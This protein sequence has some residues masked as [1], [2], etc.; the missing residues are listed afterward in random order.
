MNMTDLA[1]PPWVPFGIK[2]TSQVDTSKKVLAQSETTEDNSS[3]FSQARK[4]ALAE[5]IEAKS[6]VTKTFVEKVIILFVKMLFSK[7]N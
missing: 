4:A 5:A 3:E 6:K 7:L 1:P 2:Q